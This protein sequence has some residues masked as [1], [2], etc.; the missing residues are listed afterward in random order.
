MVWR[1]QTWE[2]WRVKWPSLWAFRGKP[3]RERKGTQSCAATRTTLS[4]MECPR[5]PWAWDSKKDRR[6]RRYLK[7]GGRNATTRLLTIWT[8][9]W[10]KLQPENTKKSSLG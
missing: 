7:S 2:I 10:T 1:N 5:W 4:G 6:S 8:N 9:L 3:I